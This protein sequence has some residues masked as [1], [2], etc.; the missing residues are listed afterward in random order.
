MLSAPGRAEKVVEGQPTKKHLG[1]PL[2]VPSLEVGIAGHE[3]ALGHA[4]HTA[5]LLQLVR[6]IQLPN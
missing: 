3:G 4:P 2:C 5:I 1:K 6:Q